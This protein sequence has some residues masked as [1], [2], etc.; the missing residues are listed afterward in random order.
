ML[1]IANLAG[2]FTGEGFANKAG[3]HP[4]AEDC[5]YLP[6]PIDIVCSP[7]TGLISSIE[8]TTQN[9]AAGGEEILDGT[10]LVATAGFIDSHTHAIFAGDRS[11]EHFS[12]W[13]GRSYQEITAAAGGI[14]STVR[15]TNQA[16]D[17]VLADLLAKR[18]RAMLTSGTTVVEVKSGYADTPAGELR[19]LRI[20]QEVR[21]QLGLP[22]VRSTFLG[23]HAL[24]GGWN[25]HDYC[26]AMIDLL[27]TIRKEGLA[28]FVDAFP[29]R[30]F[31][32]LKATQRFVEAAASV[33]L[34]AKVHADELTDLGTSAT[35]IRAHARSIDHLEEI[36]D[37]ALELLHTSHTVATLLPATSFFLVIP[38]A[39]ARQLI[40]SGARVALATDFNPGSAPASDFQLTNLLAASQLK[41]TPAEI[42]CA[43]TYN[44]AAA[45]AVENAV[46]VVAAGRRANLIL[47][48]D[49]PIN[50]SN[51]G[52]SFLSQLFIWRRLPAQVILAA[53]TITKGNAAY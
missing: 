45:L 5:G 11:G 25:E 50:S 24:P 31:F 8:P 14:H 47:W 52:M 39:G 51:D 37:E 34:Q 26:S 38:Y 2:V 3:R 27:P 40:H 6:G 21:K 17:E 22:E 48:D 43:C 29:E 32:S 15:A 36:S 35:M 18:L 41:M 49:E 23:L 33:G 13:A 9:P 28:D 4:Q 12:R 44:A 46:G 20:I 16:S 1:R 19:L 7:E 10:G 42:L 53:R 30:G